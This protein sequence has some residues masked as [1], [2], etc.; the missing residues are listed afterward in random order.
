MLKNIT[1]SFTAQG[2]HKVIHCSRTS[3][4]HS[5][6]KDIARSF[7]AQGH[8]KVIHCSM[9]KDIARSFTAQGHHKVIHCSRTSQGHS[10]LNAQGHRKVIHCSRT[11]QG[12]SLL[13]DIARSFTVSTECLTD[14]Q[15]CPVHVTKSLNSSDD[16]KRT[17]STVHITYRPVSHNSQV[18]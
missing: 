10:L 8:H 17:L 2:H 13:K 18:C 7:T 3:Q 14:H 16:I 12:H 9:L 1:R 5:L 11:S 6:L 15:R 4:G